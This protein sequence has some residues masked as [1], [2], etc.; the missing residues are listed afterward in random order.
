M[1]LFI[2]KYVIYMAT[3]RVLVFIF[4]Q[5]KNIK[6]YL[7]HDL[8]GLM[9]YEWTTSL[10]LVILIIMYCFSVSDEK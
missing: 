2:R 10:V 5:I 4:F 8:T 7:E 1:T 9:V 6:F 3:V